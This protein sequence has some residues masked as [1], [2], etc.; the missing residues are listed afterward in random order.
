MKP[1]ISKK[2]KMSRLKFTTE[3][4][5]RTEEQWDYV[6]FS[7]ESKF[8]LFDLMREGSFDSVL[9]NNIHLCALKAALNLEEEV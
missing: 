1:Y 3:H 8:N 4:V 9:R 2:T 6:H 7:N 5:I